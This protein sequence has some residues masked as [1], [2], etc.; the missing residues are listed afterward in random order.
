VIYA[1]PCDC[2]NEHNVYWTHLAYKASRLVSGAKHVCG[3]RCLCGA[4][5]YFLDSELLDGTAAC[6]RCTGRPAPSLN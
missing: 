4:V 6:P 3:G 2:C 5:V 1:V